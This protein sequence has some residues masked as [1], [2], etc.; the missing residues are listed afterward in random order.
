MSYSDKHTASKLLHG[1]NPDLYFE[2][3]KVTWQLNSMCLT[4]IYI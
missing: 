1:I 3:E 4:E 2:G